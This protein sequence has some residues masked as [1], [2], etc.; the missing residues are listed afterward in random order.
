LI[1]EGIV[2]HEGEIQQLKRFKDDVN[3]V[4]Y[5]FECGMSLKGFN[6]IE[7]GDI[8]E[9]FEVKEIKRKL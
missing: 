8:L 6:D 3:E 2:V 1:R 9:S 4:K 7:V 5:G